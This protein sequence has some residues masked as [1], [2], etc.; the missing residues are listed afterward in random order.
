[1]SDE[2]TEYLVNEIKLQNWCRKIRKQPI[3]YVEKIN[4]HSIKSVKQRL[5]DANKK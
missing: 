2:I 5:K 3:E 4:L 1:M